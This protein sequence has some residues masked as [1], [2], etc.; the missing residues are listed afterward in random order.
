[1]FKEEVSEFTFFDINNDSVKEFIT[2]EP[3][4]G[5]TLNIY[6][7]C[8]DRWTR[9]YQS[10]LAFGHGFSAGTFKGKPSVAVG[11]RRG[12]K[13]LNLYVYEE[14]HGGTINNKIVEEGVGPTQI[15][16]FI[17]KAKDYILSS[18][19]VKGEVALY[20]LIFRYEKYYI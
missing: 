10:D 4:H 13:A 15:K 19:K 14:A 8:S 3:C 7:N 6:S 20:H 16:I 5:N 18:N 17:Y 1:L 11:N 12:N 9:S 2:I